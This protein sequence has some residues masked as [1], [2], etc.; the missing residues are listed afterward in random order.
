M[1]SETRIE[2]LRTYLIGVISQ[3]KE[4]WGELNVDYLSEKIDS[5][6][7]DKIPTENIVETWITGTELHK[8]VYSLRSRMSYSA[9]TMN[10]IANIGFF[11][12]FENA[13]KNNNEAGV[14]PD[15]DGIQAIRCLNCATISIAN[16]NT[17]EFDIQIQ[18]EY[19]VNRGEPVSPISL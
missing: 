4:K 10:N 19:R 2:G 11:E 7:L 12:L 8:D 13:I 14:L 6:S 15:I 17:C 5:Y 9:D 18:I 16:T 1:E 3:L